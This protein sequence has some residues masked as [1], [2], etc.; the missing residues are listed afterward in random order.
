MVKIRITYMAM[1]AILLLLLWL[2]T[3]LKPEPK[4]LYNPSPSADIGWYKVS[5]TNHYTVGDLVAAFVPEEA[6]DL[7]DSRGYLPAGVPVIK[8]I[9]G[10]EGDPYCITDGYLEIGPE[11]KLKIL[12]FDSQGRAMPVLPERCAAV[13]PGYVLLIS[14]RIGR[15]FDSRYF[16]EIRISEIIGH[17]SYLGKSVDSDWS[18]SSDTGGARGLG[19]QGKIKAHSAKE[20]LTPCLHIIFYSAIFMTGALKISDC[21]IESKF[22]GGAISLKIPQRHR[23]N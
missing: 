18:E 12:P 3:L 19:A 22:K 4:L 13:S 15:S 6:E 10:I 5:Q 14:R 8:T 17:V 20:A 16:G 1:T 21:L 2:P 11:I 23:H 7:A 9:G